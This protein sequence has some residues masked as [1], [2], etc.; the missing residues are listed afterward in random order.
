M[1]ATLSAPSRVSI[2]GA[3]AGMH[4]LLDLDPSVDDLAI[5][6]AAEARD[7]R[8]RALSPMHLEPSPDRGLLLGYGRLIESQVDE[9]VDALASI[10]REHGATA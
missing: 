9:A 7:I 8:V 10:I 3:A 5:A 6:D 4:L 2:R 1:T